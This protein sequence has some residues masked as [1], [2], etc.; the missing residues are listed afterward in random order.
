MCKHIHIHIYTNT[1]IHTNTIHIFKWFHIRNLSSI[2]NIVDIYFT[3][4]L[5]INILGKKWAPP[6]SWNFYSEMT[7]KTTEVCSKVNNRHLRNTN[8]IFHMHSLTFISGKWS[9]GRDNWEPLL[10][11]VSIIIL[12]H[13]TVRHG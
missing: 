10:W 12:V 2:S 4:K 11:W 5:S 1:F 7:F 3:V 6:S 8:S 13:H 9:F